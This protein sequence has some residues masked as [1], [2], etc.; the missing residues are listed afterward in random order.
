MR[1]RKYLVIL[2]DFEKAFDSLEWSFISKSLEFFGFGEYIIYWFQTLYKNVESCVQNNGHLSERFVVRRGVRQGDPLSPYLFIIAVELLSAALKFN[3]KIKGISINNSEFLFSQYAD[4]STLSLADD[5][6]SLNEALNMISLF[7]ICSGLRANFDKTQVVWI[8]A[9][10][11]CGLELKTNIDIEWNH[12]GSFKLLG[13][14]YSLAKD[15]RYID[16]YYSKLEKIKK[17][18]NDWSLRNI[19]LLGKISY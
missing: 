10:R 7:P 3:P 2:L 8:G 16:N 14:Q 15:D 18:L 1:M 9:R 17:L 6:N 5:E 11:G 19:S 12:S 4:D 13:I